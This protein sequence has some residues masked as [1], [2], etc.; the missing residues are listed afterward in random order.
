LIFP[1]SYFGTEWK[2]ERDKIAKRSPYS[3]CSSYRIRSFII[4]SGDDLRQEHMAMQLISMVKQICNKENI[5]IWLRT[6]AVI[7]F[8]R[9]SGLIEFV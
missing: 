7:P 6:Y 5:K 2:Y 3:V 8:D 9:E 1:Q 4:K